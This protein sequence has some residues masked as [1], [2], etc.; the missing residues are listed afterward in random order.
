MFPPP[1]QERPL[2]FNT[3]DL[4]LATA[5][6]AIWLVSLLAV[7]HSLLQSLADPIMISHGICLFLATALY[8]KYTPNIPHTKKV[9]GMV[10]LDLRV[11]RNWSIPF[12]IVAGML[13]F[14][15]TA[16]AIDH[17]Q[18]DSS[19]SYLDY[20][21]WYGTCSGIGISLALLFSPR[22]LIGAGGVILPG[23]LR[24][25]PWESVGLIRN[26]AGDVEALHCREWR[27]IRWSH[28]RIPPESAARVE[29]VLPEEYRA[30]PPPSA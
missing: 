1:P 24:V 12:V 14:S 8:T 18:T 21:I 16:Q 15:L 7:K 22:L 20:L 2:R 5:L 19:R 9:L 25:I 29:A 6:I 4:L 23:S 28:A 26:Q 10:Y 17:Q 27:Q 30:S 11:R 13:V 3:R